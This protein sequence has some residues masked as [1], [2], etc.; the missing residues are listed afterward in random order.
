MLAKSLAANSD[1]RKSSFFGA[2][3]N[4]LPSNN[5]SGFSALPSGYRNNGGSYFGL[6]TQGFWWFATSPY[7]VD[8]RCFELLSDSCF[9]SAAGV[10]IFLQVFGFSV[11]LVRN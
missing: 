7:S 3:G 6:S 11:R 1:W 8:A 4:D 9:V 10:S 5:K 2:P